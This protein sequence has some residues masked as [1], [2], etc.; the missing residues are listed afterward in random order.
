MGFFCQVQRFFMYIIH[1]LDV[2]TFGAKRPPLCLF[3][4]HKYVNGTCEHNMDNYNDM[5]DI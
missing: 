3:S 4:K 5:H 2:D 1:I